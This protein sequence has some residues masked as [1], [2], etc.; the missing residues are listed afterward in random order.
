LSAKAVRDRD[1]GLRRNKCAIFTA[2]SMTKT[3]DA[4]DWNNKNEELS[5]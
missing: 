1:L 3:A 4:A 2:P 5:T